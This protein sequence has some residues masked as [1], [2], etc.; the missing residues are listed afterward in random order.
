MTVNSARTHYTFIIIVT[1]SLLAMETLAQNS[2][3]RRVTTPATKTKS[4]PITT[5][6]II[7]ASEKLS[8]LGFWVTQD[9]DSYRQALIAFQKIHELKRT[10]KLTRTD[11]EAIQNA[12]EI[13]PK[14]AQKLEENKIRVEIDLRRQVLFVINPENKIQRILPIS[15]GN[16]K[17][18]DSEGFVRDAMVRLTPKRQSC[19]R[20]S[21]Q[22]VMR[23]WAMRMRFI[24][25]C[26]FSSGS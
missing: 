24:S 11:F 7:T 1:L 18:F 22:A 9:P 26:N 4:K 2:R 12:S 17:E 16:D 6:E 15:S 25:K 20:K 19:G 3:A 21:R 13:S 23:R 5:K 14:E 8:A 10:G